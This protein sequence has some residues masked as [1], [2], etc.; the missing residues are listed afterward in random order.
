[1]EEYANLKLSKLKGFLTFVDGPPIF[2]VSLS[3]KLLS[4]THGCVVSRTERTHVHYR[5]LCE[6]LV[7]DIGGKL[8]LREREKGG[9][10]CVTQP[11]RVV[12]LQSLI[13]TP[14]RRNRMNVPE[15][16]SSS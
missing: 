14:P 6:Y 16:W 5:L 3:A 9:R 1:M 11:S 15:A 12:K 13:L 8:D 4:E 2:V 10:R 7:V